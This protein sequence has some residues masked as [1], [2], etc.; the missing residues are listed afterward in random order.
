VLPASEN[1]HKS[2]CEQVQQTTSLFDH[3]IGKREQLTPT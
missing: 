2:G 1:L 3:I